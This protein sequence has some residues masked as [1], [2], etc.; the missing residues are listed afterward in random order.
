M[1]PSAVPNSRAVG[2]RPSE[3][4]SPRTAK[5]GSRP[6]APH[7]AHCW[8]RPTSPN[9]GDYPSRRWRS[10]SR[11]RST[12]AITHSRGEGAVRLPYENDLY[13]LGRTTKPMMREPN[14]ISVVLPVLDEADVLEAFH[15]RISSA[16]GE[17][18]FELI[19]V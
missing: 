4:T 1:S 8:I 2:I 16:L 14:L 6:A 10:R 15:E 13:G 7:A 17:W 18:D 19:F 3:P 11:P 12:I 5:C 9:R